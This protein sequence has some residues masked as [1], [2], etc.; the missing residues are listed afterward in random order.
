LF[1]KTHNQETAYRKTDEL[2]QILF[3]HREKSER[4]VEHMEDRHQK[5]IKQFTASEDR[6]ISDQRILMG[7]QVS[8]FMPSNDF[9]DPSFER[10]SKDRVHEGVPLQDEPPEERRQAS[11]RPDP[12]AA[13][14][15]AKTFQRSYRCRICKFTTI[16]RL[17]L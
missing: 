8:F 11:T 6:K 5:Q 3:E 12:R 17:R 10:G 9:L 4:I 1:D 2:K 15:G 13:A 16:N 14:H 7:L